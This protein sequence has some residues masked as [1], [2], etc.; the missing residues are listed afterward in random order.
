MFSDI[1]GFTKITE[2]MNS[3]KSFSFVNEILSMI[4]PVIKKNNGFVDK[5]IGDCIMA[6]FPSAK[7][8]INCGTQMMVAIKEFN[9]EKIKNGES[10]VHLGIGLN[11]GTLMMGVLGGSNRLNAT[12]I[13][14][15]V[16]IASRVENL[17]KSFGCDFLL[18]GSCLE[19]I[20]NKSKFNYVGTY[21]LKGKETPQKLYFIDLENQDMI[22]YEK[23]FKLF[24]ERKF[25]E[26][27]DIYENIG[28]KTSNYLKSIVDLYW[29]LDKEGKLSKDWDGSVK[30]SKDGNPE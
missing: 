10:Q 21:L 27:I 22:N 1:R 20:E 29:G 4:T 23:G 12:V 13:S 9:E 19:F 2:N 6:L 3:L 14:D 16:N 8:G 26:S 24:Q 15:A 18:T 28:T 30:L 17:T 5:F 25:K 7:D 11:Y